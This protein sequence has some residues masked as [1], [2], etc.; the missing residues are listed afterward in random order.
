MTTLLN[1]TFTDTNGT[2]TAA[3]TPNS[4]GTWSLHTGTSPVCYSN[5]MRAGSGFGYCAHS[6]AATVDGESTTLS[7]KAVTANKVGPIVRFTSAS[8]GSFYFVLWS[9]T[10]G[11]IEIW[12]KKNGSLTLLKNSD[13]YQGSFVDKDIT[14]TVSGTGATVSLD[15]IIEG[16]SRSTYSDTDAN[17]VTTLGAAGFVFGEG[18]SDTTGWRIDT[19]T[20]TDSAT[21]PATGTTLTGPSTG[22]VGVASSNFTV[23]VTPVGGAITGTLVVTPSSG[24]AGGTFTPSTV[25]LTTGSPT[26]TFTYTPAIASV[27][28]ISITDSGGLT[29]ATPITHTV[30]AA[31]TV[32]ITTPTNGRIHQRAGTAGTIAVAGSYT[33]T[34]SGI[35]ARLVLDGTST[36][37]STFDWTTK[38]AAPSGGAFSFSFTGVPQ[39]G[40][41]NVQVRFTNDIIANATSGKVG[42]G[43]L[44]ALVGQSNAWYWFRSR[45]TATAPN[46]L[47]RTYG[48]IGTWAAPDTAA[49]SASIA[50]GN[51][52]ATALN[53]PIGLLDYPKDSGAISFWVPVS[54][55]QNR[56]FT[57]AVA[58]LDG[59]IEAAIWIQGENDAVLGR[60]QAQY[61]ADLGTL[62]ADWRT[63]FSQAALPVI[64]PTLGNATSG[65]YTDAQAQAIVEAQIQKS[66]DTAIYRLDRRDLP[67]LDTVHPTS[68]GFATLGARAAHVAKFLAGSASY[69]RGPSIASATSG[70]ATTVDVAI[71]HRG[72]TDITPSSAITGFRLT[73]ASGSVPISSAARIAANSIR[74]TLGRGI[75]ATPVLDYMYGVNPVVTGAV[76]DN[77]TAVLP[78]ESIT[79]VSV[80]ISTVTGVS[81]SPS[82]AIVAGTNTQ[83]FT[84]TVTGTGTPSQAVT[85]TASSGSISG[86]GLFTAPA[87]TSVPQTIT[88]TATSA[89]DGATTGTATVTVPEAAITRTVSIQLVNASNAAQAS[90]TGLK[91]AWFDQI[92]PDLFTAPTDKGAAETTD[93]SGNLVI[94]LANSSKIAGQT[95][96]LIVTNSDGTATQ[97][98]AHKAFSGPVVLV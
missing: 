52:M 83:Q 46:A 89:Q 88:V 77:S 66:G 14:L 95:G 29:D 4:G 96:W 76:F 59:K 28:S 6:V 40:W 9:Y 51:A 34:P 47:V 43:A 86:L 78:L 55:T 19:I 37:V 38:D 73:D 33:G 75:A 91:W 97:S 62:F 8:G 80:S 30:T 41:Y 42:V 72:G 64:V 21:V 85:W 36:V 18:G 71:T 11:V 65:L 50:F 74:L 23:G 56:N 92:T 16:A 70:T 32:N 84:A 69:Y 93:S 44:Y 45:S 61:Y 7:L 26:A 54:G 67:L 87:A 94:F 79:G 82:T 13:T 49:M 57:N 24:G 10:T 27:Q 25:S 1:D 22:S 5:G 63:Q 12:R 31:G 81:V 53:I 39:G 35:E 3:H 90:L 98:P 2:L 60:T 15:C 20:A 58:A 68:A 17:R 48:N